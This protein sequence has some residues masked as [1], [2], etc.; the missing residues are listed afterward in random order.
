MSG[1]TFTTFIDGAALFD[2][3]GH[4]IMEITGFSQSVTISLWPH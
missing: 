3:L 2:G 1:S 4:R